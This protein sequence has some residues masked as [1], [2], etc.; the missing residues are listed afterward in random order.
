MKRILWL[1]LIV[2]ISGFTVVYGQSKGIKKGQK[3]AVVEIL[4]FHGKQRCATCI[5][6]GN[7]SQEVINKFFA[8]EVKQ[9]RVAFKEIDFSTPEGEKIADKYRV[10]SS[11]L[12]VNQWKNGREKPNDMTVFG[13]KYARNNPQVFKNGLKG[14]IEQLLK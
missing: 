14:K 9:G 3:N 7:S 5:A 2:L 1:A 13:F 4:Y 12:F 6:I 8:S 11:S 10:S